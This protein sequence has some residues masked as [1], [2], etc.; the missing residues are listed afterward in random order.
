MSA[1]TVRFRCH[2]CGATVDPAHA[3][4]FRCP[5]A[6]VTWDDTDHVLA[7]EDAAS[8]FPDGGES[9]P[10]VRYRRLLSPYRLARKAGLSD[11]AWAD[12][13]EGL[14]AFRITPMSEQAQL[15][16]ALGL[17]SRLWVKDETGNVSGSHKARHVMGVMLYLRVLEIGKLPAGE[18][19]RDRQ[20]ASAPP[21][22]RSMSSSRPTPT[23]W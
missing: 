11:A 9:N 12:L 5:N 10:F 14:G 13:V 3:L 23:Q 1:D 20:G 7:P 8:V 19:L 16:A 2:G 6:G 4:P 21:I 22:G 15:A 17:D 18:G